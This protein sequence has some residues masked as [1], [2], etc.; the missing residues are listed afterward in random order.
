MIR[1][2][3]EEWGTA[4]EL[5]ARLGRDITEDMVYRWRER[6]GLVEIKDGRK[7]YSPLGQAAIIER[8]KRLA[9]R[10]RPRSLDTAPVAA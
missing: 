9:Q 6:D 2:G 10:G 4:A 3:G 5:A 7:A 8:D 1:V